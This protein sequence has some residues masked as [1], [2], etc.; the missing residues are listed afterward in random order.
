MSAIATQYQKTNS[1][2]EQRGDSKNE[3]DLTSRTA[4]ASPE[5]VMTDREETLQ[6]SQA[7]DSAPRTEQAQLN[8]RTVRQVNCGRG[9]A[10]LGI[11]SLAIGGVVG[12]SYALGQ[13]S[14]LGMIV[15]ETLLGVGA[16]HSAMVACCP[17]IDRGG[18]AP[19]IGQGQRDLENQVGAQDQPIARTRLD[20]GS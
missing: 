12:V 5:V 9:M 15:I 20:G 19:F 18:D 11:G 3:G 4:W 14:T 13:S 17:P 1:N 16:V 10:V 7:A 8:E 2:N 6:S